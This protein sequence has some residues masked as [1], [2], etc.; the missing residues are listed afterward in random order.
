M[1]QILKLYDG[2]KIQRNE[3]KSVHIQLPLHSME[4][5]TKIRLFVLSSHNNESQMQLRYHN[6]SLDHISNLNHIEI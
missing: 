3:Y 6:H 2:L 4:E 1:V 5:I